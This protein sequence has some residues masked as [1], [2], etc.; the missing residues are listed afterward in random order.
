MPPDLVGGQVSF[1]F[2]ES[3][4]LGS[5]F[6]IS[7]WIALALRGGSHFFFLPKS[8]FWKF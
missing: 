3:G 4:S 2:R 8:D 1:K 5:L 6:Y 7:K